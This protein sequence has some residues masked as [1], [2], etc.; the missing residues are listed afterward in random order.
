MKKTDLFQAISGA[1]QELLSRAER[2]FQ[3]TRRTHRTGRVVALLAA[4]LSVA[5]VLTMLVALPLMRKDTTIPGHDTP[6]GSTPVGTLTPNEGQD[7]EKMPYF[8]LSSSSGLVYIPTSQEDTTEDQ[9]A[10]QNN[11]NHVQVGLR[12][13]HPAAPLLP[14]IIFQCGED[15]TVELTAT[16]GVLGE[17]VLQDTGVEFM[18]YVCVSKN[19]NPD[20]NED[21][22]R[23]Y[24]LM[25]KLGEKD[26]FGYEMY[27]IGYNNKYFCPSLTVNG[28][29]TVTWGY[30]KGSTTEPNVHMND[31]D[32]VD[33][34]V[35]NAD[36]EVIAAG[37]IYVGVR[38]LVEVNEENYYQLDSYEEAVNLRRKNLA[39]TA[40]D[41]YVSVTELYGE[42]F[43][44]E[45]GRVDEEARAAY[46]EMHNALKQVRDIVNCVEPLDKTRFA[47]LG[48][49]VEEAPTEAELLATKTEEEKA[50]YA[51]LCERIAWLE[52]DMFNDPDM[53]VLVA[54]GRFKTE[55]Y[56]DYASIA[57]AHS[58]TGTVGLD[59]YGGN[60]I[61]PDLT[62]LAYTDGRRPFINYDQ[63]GRPHVN[64]NV[65]Y[66]AILGDQYYS[67]VEYVEPYM[68]YSEEHHGEDWRD[69][70]AVLEDGTVILIHAV[71]P[72]ARGVV[73]IIPPAT[74]DDASL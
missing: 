13:N 34:T 10:T 47:E 27:D 44:T 36:G 3:H 64:H 31:D 40:Y 21:D 66:Y 7:S 54:E 16:H 25:A 9:S 37:C 20:P 65:K 29:A 62:I 70:R 26:E 30:L 63:N 58:S 2:S 6:A 19:P 50:L 56:K 74:I 8:P 32:F 24:Y 14:V 57:I 28:N 59:H 68:Q 73:E 38:P 12:K 41:K 18:E 60:A 43:L 23:Q 46:E 1:D 69:G 49:P 35:Y 15:C 61:W 53:G 71:Y 22:F 33:Y 11:S 39:W 52:K 51:E 4:C 17:I 55:L 72:N 5:M 67:I 42:N 48:A 45:D